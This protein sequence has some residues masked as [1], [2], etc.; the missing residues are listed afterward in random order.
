MSLSNRQI[1]HLRGLAHSLK[2]VVALGAKGLTDSVV[3]EIDH[4]LSRHELLKVRV[5]VGD[6]EERDEIIQEICE[7]TGA[8]LI[9]RVGHVATL[10]RQNPEKPRIDVGKK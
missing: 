1:R 8:E 4:A 2:V 6:R 7:R 3:D 9:Q 5:N 10:F